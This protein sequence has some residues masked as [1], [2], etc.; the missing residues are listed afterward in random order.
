MTRSPI[1]S[2]EDVKR[3]YDDLGAGQ[4]VE[5]YYEDAALDQ[6]IANGSFATAQSI[7][8]FG[9]GTGRFAQRLLGGHIPP[10]ATYIAVDVSPVMA[11]L[12]K[13]RIAAFSK[14]AMILQTDGSMHLPIADGRIDRFLCAFVIDLLSDEDARA[15]IHE[16]RRTLSAGGLLCLASLTRGRGVVPG[17]ISL[18]WTAVHTILPQRVGG[19]RPVSLRPLLDERLWKIGHLSQIAPFGI[20]SDV[21]IAKKL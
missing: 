8:E 20:A 5:A 6:V 17:L 9:C 11:G 16:A 4:D 18:L 15:L 2:T 10:A 7:F 19:C 13:D 14:R 1:L 21:L 12:A 3:L